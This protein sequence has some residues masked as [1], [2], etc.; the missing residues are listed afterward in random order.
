ELIFQQLYYKKRMY[1]VFLVIA[2]KAEVSKTFL[3]Y[4]CSKV[5][6]Q[7]KIRSLEF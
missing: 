7:S 1:L 5:L 2:S 3:P 6:P 4:F